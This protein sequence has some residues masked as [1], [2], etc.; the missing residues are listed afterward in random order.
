MIANAF[1]YPWKL[2]LRAEL[3]EA[4]GRP[5]DALRTYQRFLSLWHDADPDLLE[6]R[7]AKAREAALRSRVH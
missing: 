6:V 1:T 5:A 7:N 3:E 2:Y 4:A